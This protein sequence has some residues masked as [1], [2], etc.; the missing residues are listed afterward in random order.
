MQIRRAWAMPDSCTFSIKPIRQLV[1]RYLEWGGDWADP[2]VRNSPFKN[3]MFDTNDLDPSVDADHHLD[4]GE[5][6]HLY[7]GG[8]LDGVLFDPPYSP[9][10]I[11]ECYSGIGLEVSSEDTQSSTWSSWK[12]AA[13]DALRL[14]GTCISFGWNSGGLG[15][16][17]GFEIHEILLV[18]HGGMHNDTI[19]VVERK[20]REQMKLF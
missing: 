11:K 20:E 14:G 2:F 12:D 10:Q 8:T 1:G 5:F 18:A 3:L 7:R 19:V 17:R 6:L 9:R 4:A 15:V 16:K 13:G